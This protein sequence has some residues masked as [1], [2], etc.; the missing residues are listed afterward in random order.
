[1]AWTRSG[2]IAA[3]GARRSSHT[4]GDV[5]SRMRRASVSVEISGGV[6]RCVTMKLSWQ[7]NKSGRPAQHLDLICKYLRKALRQGLGGSF[8]GLKLMH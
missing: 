2:G 5:D 8:S 1:M 7:A 3:Q 6:L 4:A